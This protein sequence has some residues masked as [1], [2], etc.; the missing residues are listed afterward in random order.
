[1]LITKGISVGEVICLKLVTSEEVLAKLVEE[2]PTAYIVS[3]PMT[4][5][6]SATGLGL[7]Q[8]V[9]SMNPNKPVTI[10]KSHVMIPC[11]IVDRLQQ[12]YIETTSGIQSVPK[13]SIL[14]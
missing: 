7:M 4:V 13:G 9:I 2:T 5:V 1:M 6:P 3:K 10:Q 11:E 14:V 12:H 8:T